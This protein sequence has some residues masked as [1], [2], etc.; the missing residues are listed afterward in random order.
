M[1]RILEVKITSKT[2]LTHWRP[3]PSAA[4]NNRTSRVQKLLP[5]NATVA[6]W[7]AEGH[8]L[9]CQG[10]LERRWGVGGE[11]EAE[12]TVLFLCVCLVCGN[13]PSYGSA[14]CPH[15]A[16]R[17]AFAQRP[18][19]CVTVSVCVSDCVRVHLSFNFNLRWHRELV[20]ALAWAP[21]DASPPLSSIETGRHNRAKRQDRNFSGNE[22]KGGTD[23][24]RARGWR[25]STRW[26]EALSH[27]LASWPPSPSLSCPCPLLLLCLSHSLSD[28][29][30][31][32]VISLIL[33][34]WPFLPHS[35]GS[36]NKRRQP[37]VWQLLELSYQ[38]PHTCFYKLK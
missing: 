22:R 5:I 26:S 25:R 3:D 18:L 36:L 28:S 31:F 38:C 10:S 15:Y 24:D 1:I 17:G 34:Q 13:C 19:L 32:S 8:M 21:T 33:Y 35:L 16:L 9:Q 37:T 12:R 11:V 4:N 23:R 7:C 2:A 27:Q 14:E 6:G 30:C 29:L 20:Q